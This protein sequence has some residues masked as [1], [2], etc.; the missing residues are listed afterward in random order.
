VTGPGSGLS[1]EP[2]P[3]VQA[4]RVWEA[5]TCSLATEAVPVFVEFG[6]DFAFLPR[7]DLLT[8]E[9]LTRL[10]R[11]FAGLGVRKLR[12]TGGEPAAPRPGAAGRDAGRDRRR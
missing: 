10:G 11:V 7:Q 6:R 12:L 5:V 9:E 8:F 1:E 2:V 3:G 4:G